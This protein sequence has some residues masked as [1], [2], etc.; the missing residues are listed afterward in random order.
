[1]AINQAFKLVLGLILLVM[2]LSGKWK[3]NTNT[4]NGACTAQKVNGDC[5]DD[6]VITVDVYAFASGTTIYSDRSVGLQ[7]D[8]ITIGYMLD[9]EVLKVLLRQLALV[10]RR[11]Y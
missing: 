10:P 6:L 5:L 2:L 1:M 7:P 3:K 4:V 9:T 8:K 11:N